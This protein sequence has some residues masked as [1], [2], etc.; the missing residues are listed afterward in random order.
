VH[1][2]SHRDRGGESFRRRAPCCIIGTADSPADPHPRPFMPSPVYRSSQPIH[3]RTDGW[4]NAAILR[5]ALIVT[6][7]ALALVTLWRASDVVL[8]IFLGVLF[9]IAV[10]QGA[11]RLARWRIPRGLGATL[12][13]FSIAGALV[14]VASYVAPTLVEQTATIRKQLPASLRRAET[15]LNEHTSG[16]ASTFIADETAAAAG[17]TTAKAPVNRPKRVDIAQQVSDVMQ[18]ATKA[19]IDV[20]TTSITVF[21]AIGLMFVLAIYVGAEADL[22]R[23]GIL[24]LIPPAMRPR[25]GEVMAATATTLRRWLVTQSIAMVVI[26][27]ASFLAFWLIGVQAAFALALIAALLEFIPT[28]GPI[29]S[30][31][32]AVAMAFL[33]SPAKAV[34]VL[35]AA[36]VIQ[37]LENNVLIPLLMKGGV[38]LPPALTIVMQGI[39]VILF[40]FPGMLVAVPLLAAIVVPVRMLYIGD[41]LGGRVGTGEFPTGST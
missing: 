14:G 40:G 38:D 25:A 30:G 37:Q 21:A 3:P 34:A 31:A 32:I 26:G 8:L 9:G 18:I 10:S 6:I 1:E 17:D 15:W 27:V 29:V 24:S 22:Y 33:D 41:H 36:I 23:R 28:F 35:I 7:V 12:I 39:M 11:D 13:V 19:L 16:V 2:S 20:L 4:T 5:T